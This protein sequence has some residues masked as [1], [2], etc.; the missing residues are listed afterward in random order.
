MKNPFKKEFGFIFKA[1]E[2]LGEPVTI[3]SIRKK[4]EY[5]K[6]SYCL[7][8]YHFDKTSNIEKQHIIQFFDEVSN[9]Y[10]M[11]FNSRDYQSYIS[12]T[13]AAK[14]IALPLL[15]K[16]YEMLQKLQRQHAE[17]IKISPSL[18]SLR[19]SLNLQRK[20]MNLGEM[21]PLEV[22]ERCIHM[23]YLVSKLLNN[24]RQRVHL[25]NKIGHFWCFM[26]EP[27]GTPYIHMNIYFR[28]GGFNASRAMTLLDLWLKVTDGV[29]SCILFDFP[30]HYNNTV[31]YNDKNIIDQ[32]KPFIIPKMTTKASHIV[33]DDYNQTKGSWKYTTEGSS[34]LFQGYLSQVVRETY[35]VY[36]LN[37]FPGVVIPD[38][39][40]LSANNKK[41]K[42]NGLK[43]R[44]YALSQ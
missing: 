34:K 29:G 25:K 42:I 1:K 39:I 12:V 15:N 33:V 40:A 38:A 24:M 21:P 9:I 23:A 16:K 4:I 35:P 30:R 14:Q 27:N 36:T 10:E 32:I 43:V 6:K 19:F 31:I 28:H 3:G 26:K 11:N 22:K 2:E 18:Y 41:R 20:H 13:T 17:L 7:D 5:L 37:T 8:F 44:S